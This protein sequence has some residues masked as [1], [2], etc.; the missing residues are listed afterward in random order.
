MSHQ[1]SVRGCSRDE[2]LT[3]GRAALR[4]PVKKQDAD[5]VWEA[6]SENLLQQCISM[7][8]VLVLS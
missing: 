4:A 8:L 3:P 1:P 7:W 6:A 2:C 5:R